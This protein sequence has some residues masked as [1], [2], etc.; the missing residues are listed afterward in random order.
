MEELKLIRIRAIMG[1]LMA[2][3]DLAVSNLSAAFM[4]ESVE[5]LE[6]ERILGIISD[7]NSKIQTL[8]SLFLS[9]KEEE[10]KD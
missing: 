8:Q 9:K 3:R 7:K 10:K 6:I 4:S 2:K 1:E 5:S